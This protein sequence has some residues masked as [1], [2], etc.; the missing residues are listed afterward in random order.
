MKIVKDYAKTGNWNRVLCVQLWHDASLQ[1]LLRS[2]LLVNLW[3]SPFCFFLDVLHPGFPGIEENLKRLILMVLMGKKNKKEKLLHRL[4]TEH[5]ILMTSG[6][7]CDMTILQSNNLQA[8]PWQQI[9]NKCFERAFR[10][11]LMTGTKHLLTLVPRL[12]HW[13]T[14]AALVVLAS[15]LIQMA[16]Q[17]QLSRHLR[18]VCVDGRSD[19]AYW[20]V[21]FF[22]FPSSV[23]FVL[24]SGS[25]FFFKCLIISFVSLP[26]VFDLS[27]VFFCLFVG[28]F[29]W[30][31]A[32]SHA[33]ATCWIQPES[34]AK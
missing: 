2:S 22:F 1:S 3:P 5:C 24:L 30:D 25:N 6:S 11:F 32:R 26:F 21:Y 19:E 16:G 14:S 7:H 29:A 20:S 4:Q 10:T 15:C 17:G 28:Y 18:G 27:V 8:K 34:F 13:Y 9:L 12:C 23:Y 31:L 33:V